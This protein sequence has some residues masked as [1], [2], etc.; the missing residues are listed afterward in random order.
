[1]GANYI[2]HELQQLQNQYREL[3][4]QRQEDTSQ[5]KQLKQKILEYE[6]EGSV[7]FQGIS[8]DQELRE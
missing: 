8:F 6:S 7:F 4:D 1:M 5:G 3:F 2:P